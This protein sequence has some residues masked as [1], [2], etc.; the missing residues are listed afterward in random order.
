MLQ[1]LEDI[2]A[3]TRCHY[4]QLTTDPD[5]QSLEWWA[6]HQPME[7]QPAIEALNQDITWEELNGVLHQLKTGECPGLDGLPAEFLRLCR[8]DL[9]SSSPESAMGTRCCCGHVPRYSRATSLMP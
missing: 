5:S 7:Q 4:S 6:D 2:V 8:V 3:A 1:D 9:T